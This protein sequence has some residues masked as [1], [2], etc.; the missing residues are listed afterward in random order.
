MLR[1]AAESQEKLDNW[2]SLMVQ[3]WL[4][5][6][7]T[8]IIAGCGGQTGKHGDHD[9]LEPWL[10]KDTEIYSGRNTD[11]QSAMQTSPQ[12]STD[13]KVPEDST[14]DDYVKY[15]VVNNPELEAAFYRWRTALE[16]VP[17][18]KTLPDPQFTFGIVID[19]VDKSSEYMGERYSI[20]QMFPWF[21]KLRLRGDVALEEAQAEAQ[22]FESIRLR[23]IAQVAQAYFEYAYLHQAIAI[24]RDNLELLIHLESVSRAMYRAGTVGL[25]D[26]NR[27]QVEIGRAE[28][29][30]HSLEDLLG[31]AAVELNSLL[32]RT[33][34]AYL[35]P[36]TAKTLSNAIN[37]LPDYSDEKWIALAKENNPELAATRHDAASQ[38]HAIDLAHKDFFPDIEI[39][40]EYA[41]DATARMAMMDNGGSDMISLMVS[42]NLPVWRQKYKASSRETTA[43]Y[44]EAMRQ[45][46]SREDKLNAEIKRALFDYRDSHRKIELYGNTLLPKATESLK[47]TET[48]YR[49]DDAAFA[50]L[51]DAQRVMLEFAL[52]HQR[53]IADSAMAITRVQALI[54]RDPDLDV[55]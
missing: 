14:F 7:F 24:A 22:R 46:R 29:Q 6:N 40:A 48:A 41:R 54:G 30:V 25:S 23:L 38:R 28:D 31:A 35:P 32:G 19:E 10:K 37:D 13:L 1:D 27:A 18:V 42:I 39:G 21:G 16:R 44:G 20:T 50:D 53:A 3:A 5:L 11:M 47:I 43:R 12:A 52:S 15:A 17:Q 55:E 34:Q 26:V 9:I 2:I 8:L 45:I 4:I 33:A 36:V 49:A 51:I